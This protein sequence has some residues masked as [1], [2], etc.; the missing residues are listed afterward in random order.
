MRTRLLRVPDHIFETVFFSLALSQNREEDQKG[1]HYCN[2]P[3][4]LCC[5]SPQDA[6]C[7]CRGQ[8]PKR[9][10]R[11]HEVGPAQLKAQACF[12]ASGLQIFLQINPR[13]FHR[14]ETTGATSQSTPPQKIIAASGLP[15]SRSLLSN[16]ALKSAVARNRSMDH[17][18]PAQIYSATH[19]RKH[20]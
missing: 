16:A 8:K 5:S 19:K 14:G 10:P 12:A 15:V 7:F 17:L 20:E 6:K 18:M 2:S 9:P 1:L 13:R 11:A 4:R 3:T